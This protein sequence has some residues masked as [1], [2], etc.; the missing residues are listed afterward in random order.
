LAT[1]FIIIVVSLGLSLTV[2]PVARWLGVRG[3]DDERLRRDMDASL[4][5][6]ALAR[7]DAAIEEAQ[8]DEDPIPE[9]VVNRLQHDAKNRVDSA[10]STED[11]SVTREMATR[12]LIELARA[13]VRAEQEEVLRL[14]DEE[15]FPDALV[16]KKM[17]SLDLRIQALGTER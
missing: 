15:G 10:R 6:A 13:M 12:R 7:L 2:A 5:R 17:Q 1:T 11:V 14:R 3:D 4:A 8:N 16:R 9:E